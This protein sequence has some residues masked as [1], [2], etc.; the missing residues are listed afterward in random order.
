M[1]AAESLLRNEAWNKKILRK[2]VMVWVQ[3]EI[4]YQILMLQLEQIWVVLRSFQF[5]VFSLGLS[6]TRCHNLVLFWGFGYL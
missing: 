3:T 4:M 6:Y 2:E 1:I 5:D